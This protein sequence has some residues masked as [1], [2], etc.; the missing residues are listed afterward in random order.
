LKIYVAKLLI[1]FLY[2][3][4]LAI[5]AILFTFILKFVLLG[6]KYSWLTTYLGRGTL[7]HILILN[8]VGTIVYSTFIVTLSFMLIM[9]VRVNVAVI[10]IGLAIGFLGSSISVALMKSFSSLVGILKWN[11]LN[12]IF[13]MQQ[14]SN[15]S[16][17]H[18][19]NLSTVQIVL[20]TILYG[21]IFAEVG[22]VLFKHRRV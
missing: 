10:G 4:L 5:I 3:V 2:G 9:L 14:L 7:L 19:S 12:M 11:P 21:S 22:F 16:Y 8:M 13:V 15:S 6:N 17:A 18:I 20:A 1:I